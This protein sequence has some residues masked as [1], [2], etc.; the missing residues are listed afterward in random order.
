MNLGHVSRHVSVVKDQIA[1]MR[2]YSRM[3]KQ[4]L[5]ARPVLL[6][7]Q[8]HPLNYGLYFFL[9]LLFGRREDHFGRHKVW[10][11]L[12]WASPLDRGLE[13]IT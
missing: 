12:F 6:K 11:L 1:E 4:Y 2:Q 10:L 13:I 7:K 9:L 8:D 3:N 5:S